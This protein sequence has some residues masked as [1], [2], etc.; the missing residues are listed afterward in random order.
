MSMPT[1]AAKQRVLKGRKTYQL[2][3]EGLVP[4]I[5]YGAGGD[6]ENI[7]IDRNE[8]VRVFRTSGE[9]T[10]V[11]LIIDGG[12]TR[13]VLIQ[14]YQLDP[15]RDEVIHADFRAVD[16]NTP[17]EAEV[18]LNFIGE[19]LAVKGLG[20][21]LVKARESVLIKA[22]PK[23]LVSSLDVDLTKLATFDDAI[24]IADLDTPEGVAFVD[25]IERTIA[26][27]APPRS[28][29]EMAALDEAVSADVSAVEVA[30]DKK[31]DGDGEEK[32][33]APSEEKAE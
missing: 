9:S 13:N 12:T 27:V 31:E 23:D 30:G 20:G 1:L 11:E 15:V 8:F 17:I 25:D 26:I 3:N 21:T 10:L 32:A 33:E 7:T 5:V 22:L 14:D 24:R 2:R 19:S 16:M 4:A 6:P 28:E 29:A 18:K